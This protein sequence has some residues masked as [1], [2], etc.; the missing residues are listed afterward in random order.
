MVAFKVP[1]LNQINFTISPVNTE[2]V[3][4][5]KSGLVP[6]FEK[7]EQ[8]KSKTLTHPET[9][10]Y[11]GD[12][13]GALVGLSTKYENSVDV[14]YIDPPY[15]TGKQRY[16][17]HDK[18]L[19]KKHANT[20]NAWLSMMTP[21]LE[22]SKK[23]LQDT[24]IIIVAIGIQE[25]PYLKMLMDALYGE[26][27]FVSMITMPG[28]LKNNVPHVS[29][30]NDYWL[31]YAK[32]LTALK[33]KKVVWR[34]QKKALE[35]ILLK[36]KTFVTETGSTVI[37]EKKLREYYATP[38]AKLLFEKEPGLKMYNKLDS[39]GRLYRASDLSSPSGKGGQ[40]DV[41]NPETG[42]TVTVPSRGWLHNQTTFLKYVEDGL[43]LWN[44]KK[45]PSYKR[46]LDENTKIVK[47]DLGSLH[48]VNPSKTLQKMIGRNKFTF[49]KD[50]L[51]VA[52]WLDYVIPDFRKK[53]IE[54]PPLIMDFFA[55]SGTTAHAVAELN[56]LN[57]AMYKTILIT[58]KENNIPEEVTIPRLKALF[59]G[60]W[61]TGKTNPAPGLF[62]VYNVNYV[63]VNEVKTS[64]LKGVLKRVYLSKIKGTL[65]S[66]KEYL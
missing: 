63:P 13:L 42:E 36:T 6:V 45:A 37:A 9:E 4:L 26:E 31:I 29:T 15:N 3:S 8:V 57:N 66:L 50:H 39:Q 48:R 20:H 58:S 54:N 32:N 46:Y 51:N 27:N 11:L 59:S 14:I 64:G 61:V 17:Y 22:L 35:T 30:S 38:E 44:G 18:A 47:S 53:D 62:T 7:A 24:G 40:Y 43:I 10:L 28:V 2:S 65:S 25:Q 5:L 56:L 21:R 12:N 33:E 49:P 19:V 55:G 23:F 52:E 41:I 34:E 16:S 1:M 60:K